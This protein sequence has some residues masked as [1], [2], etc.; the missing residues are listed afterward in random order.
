[1]DTSDSE[2]ILQY[3]IR[4]TKQEEMY[5]NNIVKLCLFNMDG[6][7]RTENQRRRIID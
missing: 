5:I 1:M 4:R 2:E 7:M 3:I 6:S